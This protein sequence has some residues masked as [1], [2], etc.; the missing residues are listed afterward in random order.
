MTTHATLKTDIALYMARDDLEVYIPTFIRLAESR[1]AK[2]V[3]VRAMETSTDLTLSS[4]SVSIPSG[5]LAA[6]RLYFDS[7][8]QRGLT[9]VTPDAFYKSS[10]Y[11]A[12]GNPST[13]TIEGDNF[14]FAPAPSGSPVAKLL[15]FKKFDALAAEADTNWLLENA[16]DVYLYACLAETKAFIEDDEQA[17]KW[18]SVYKDSV[19]NLN[20]V[21]RRSRRMGPLRR[22]GGVTP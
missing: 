18:A 15:Y 2:D 16:Y 14:V 8:T 4:Q 12:A 7:T 11:T 19:A 1:I 13:F 9:Y 17:A 20:K 3:R 21:E 22:Q 10:L 5:F 6:R